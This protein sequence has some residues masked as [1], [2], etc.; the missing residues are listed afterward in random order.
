MRYLQTLL[1]LL[2]AAPALAQQPMMQQDS[3]QLVHMPPMAQTVMRNDMKNHLAALNDIV[4]FLAEDK[5]AAAADTA[6][7][8]LGTNSMGRHAM[9]GQGPGRFM[10]ETMRQ[11]GWNMHEA[12][13]EF[14][15][16]ALNGDRTK[17]LSAFHQLSSACVACHMSFRI[18]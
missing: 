15:A 7:K 10:P 2:F 5:L 13:S 17:A 12:A 4:G 16:I 9:M 11:M 18:R 3:R 8:R 1:A 14:A 6:E